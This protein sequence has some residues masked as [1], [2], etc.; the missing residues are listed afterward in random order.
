M[1]QLRNNRLD[2]IDRQLR[3]KEK[4]IVRLNRVVDFYFLK[5]VRGT[6]SAK[7]ANEERRFAK[8]IFDIVTVLESI[9]SELENVK[10]NMLDIES[11]NEIIDLVRGILEEQDELLKETEKAN[12]A[13]ILDFLQ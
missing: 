6:S 9:V 1:L 10:N 12:N 8:N 3:L 13:K 5:L 11:F 2:S 7:A 4:V